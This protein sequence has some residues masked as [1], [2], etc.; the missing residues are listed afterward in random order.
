MVGA[1][2]RPHHI[3][4]N[5][6]G[7]VNALCLAASPP[8]AGTAPGAGAVSNRCNCG[9][10][11]RSRGGVGVGWGAV[12]VQ[13]EQSDESRLAAFAG[14]CS[15]YF[16]K[17]QKG[18][19]ASRTMEVRRTRLLGFFAGSRA[20]PPAAL[21]PA[22]TAAFFATASISSLSAADTGRPGLG[23]AAPGDASSAAFG[24]AAE[25]APSA[26]AAGLLAVAA[27]LVASFFAT[28][29]GWNILLSIS[30]RPKA[31]IAEKQFSDK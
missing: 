4:P 30:R 15:I 21:P 26:A 11:I 31:Y 29:L 10:G 27:P 6:G 14:S 28:A 3:T 2:V 5:V 9:T 13:R 22:S 20:A 18:A 24:A 23:F 1:G 17:M 12:R 8:A 25:E 7:R 16:G 19:K